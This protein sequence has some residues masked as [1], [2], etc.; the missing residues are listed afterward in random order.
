MKQAFCNI[1]FPVVL[2]GERL[3]LTYSYILNDLHTYLLIPWSRVLLKKLTVSQL[4]KKF[5]AFYGT[6]K[7]IIAFTRARHVSLSSALCQHFVTYFSNWHSKAFGSCTSSS[8]VCISVCLTS[9]TP[10]TFNSWEKWFLHL[11]K[12]LWE[13]NDITLLIPYS[14]SSR[15]VTLLTIADAPIQVPNIF[16]LLLVSSSLNLAFRYSFFLFLRCLLALYC[17]YYLHCFDLDPVP[18]AF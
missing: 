4:V 6:W 2:C 5:P 15:L 17:L 12:I 18:T 1:T 13:C 9:L 10:C 7:F 3:I 14:L 16:I 11:A 8:A